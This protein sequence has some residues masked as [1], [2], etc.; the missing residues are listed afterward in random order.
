[1]YV[2]AGFEAGP[3]FNRAIGI[4]EHIKEQQSITRA[5]SKSRDNDISHVFEESKFESRE[6]P[7]TV[8]EGRGRT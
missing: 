2:K 4:Q 1:M 7:E 6:L 5:L 8:G 3:G